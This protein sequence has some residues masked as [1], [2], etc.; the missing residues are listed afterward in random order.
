MTITAP[1]TE[2]G[3]EPAEAPPEL[4]EVMALHIAAASGDPMLA[5]DDI[6]VQ[7][8]VGITGD[9]YHGSRHRHVSVQ[10]AEE[11]A[12][13]STALGRVID[14][15]ATRRTITLSHGRI[16]TTPGTLLTIGGVRLEVVRIA[17]PC[18][19][20][21]D[22]IGRGARAALRRRAGVVC[23][24]I[25]SGRVGVGDAAVSRSA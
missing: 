17:A 19:V 23:R 18:A 22:E 2:P 20:M 25:S 11:L 14:P 3:E 6:H 9:R 15:A 12:E 10:S 7:A 1:T 21:D 8:G 24:A 5:V 13:A 4:G 16:P